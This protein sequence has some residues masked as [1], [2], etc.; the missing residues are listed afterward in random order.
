MSI[1]LR[2]NWGGP[3]RHLFVFVDDIVNYVER[4]LKGAHCFRV[5]L[6]AVRLSELGNRRLLRGA[7]SAENRV[8]S[9][10]A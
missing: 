1:E 2:F 9:G 8:E 10:V 4:D 6:Q 5:L 3:L 7:G